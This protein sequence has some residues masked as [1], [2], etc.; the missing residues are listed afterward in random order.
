MTKKITITILALLILSGCGVQKDLEPQFI[1]PDLTHYV[2]IFELEVDTKVQ[3]HVEFEPL[4]PS[5]NGVCRSFSSGRSEV[6]IDPGFWTTATY[7]Q[8]VALMSHEL[9]H[10][11][12]DLGHV[13]KRDKNNIGNMMS[14]HTTDSTNCVKKHGLGT[15][16]K[17]AL[18]M[19]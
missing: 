8:R 6:I 2:E 9:L 7:E 19:E 5:V 10:C 17:L 14:P 18:G 13:E 3:S 11:E 16:I 1:D 4:S 15:C 12:F